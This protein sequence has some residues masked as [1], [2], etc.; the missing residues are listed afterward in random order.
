MN[1][2][3]RR[4]LSQAL[5]LSFAL[6]IMAGVVVFG[7]LAPAPTRPPDD[8]LFGGPELSYAAGAYSDIE[9]WTVDDQYAAL[10]GFLR[11]CA[12]LKQADPAAPANPREAI[13]P[14]FEGA[15]FSGLIGDW[16]KACADGEALA[17]ESFS[18]PADAAAAARNF[19]EAEFVPFRIIEKRQRREG[20]SGRPK[21]SRTGLVTGYFEP[22]YRAS[23]EPTSAEPAPL[24]A[25][26][27]DLV[28]V[29]L[30]SFSTKLAGERIAGSVDG[31]RLVPYPDH[32]GINEGALG[33][34]AVPLAFLGADDLF[35]LQIQG[36]GRLSFADGSVV[37]VGYDGQNGRP[38]SA[39]GKFLLERGALTRENISMQTIRAWLE[40]ASPEEARA[41]REKN[42]SYVFF[43]R[44]DELPDPD[45][46]PLGSEGVQLT[47]M[48]SVAVDRRFHAMGAPIWLNLE[49]EDDA[50]PVERL[51]IA[52][53]EGGAIKGPARADIFVGAG[54]EAG[55]FA[56]KL[57]AEAEMFALV[58][59]R[60]A[61]RFI[62][63]KG[64][65]R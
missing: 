38:Y 59:K 23:S 41:L 34:R 62:A 42:E 20:V 54:A 40:A 57:K 22:V 52:Q 64:R 28:M 19:F 51:F 18:N 29:D 30:G 31:G 8:E 45:L 44:L 14:D 13:G 17:A 43:R 46:G 37:R 33:A 6:A 35:F 25:R 3:H 61:E 11:S 15:S 7:G 16:L 9:G 55:E 32:A 53:D 1:F 50:P 26:P 24:L 48:R 39:I 2:Q 63:A 56:G 47:P 12:R 49:R 4:T 60:A 27:A 65:A 5:I 21:I 10:A 58:P 36:S